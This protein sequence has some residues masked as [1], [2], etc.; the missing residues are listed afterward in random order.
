M[1]SAIIFLLAVAATLSACGD[2]AK[3]SAKTESSPVR[4]SCTTPEQAGLK[5]ADLTRKLVDLKKLGTITPEEYASLNGMMSSGFRAWAD[6]Q[7]LKAY[8]ATLDRVSK[9][10]GLD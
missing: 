1:R 6:Q 10:A 9:S 8:C 7:D 5:A 3:Q 4:K 2:P